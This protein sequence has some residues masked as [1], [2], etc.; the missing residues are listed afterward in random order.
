[1]LNGTTEP[2]PPIDYP[3]IQIAGRFYTL[4]YSLF[5]QYNLDKAG[6][7][8]AELMQTLIPR[9]PDGKI[10]PTPPMKAGRVV[11]MMTLLSAC[12]AH[13]FSENGESIWTPDKWAATI[14]DN[15][16]AECCKAV[17]QAVIKAP[18]AAAPSPAPPAVQEMGPG[19][20][21]Q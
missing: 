12:A 20:Q 7:N 9:L 6:V 4:K 21:L 8:V 17:A 5:A 15:L 18:Q 2:T 16:W 11:A 19:G 3:V 10:D 1:M 14:P 13:N